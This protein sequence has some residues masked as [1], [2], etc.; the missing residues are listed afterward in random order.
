MIFSRFLF[1]YDIGTFNFLLLKLIIFLNDISIFLLT[2]RF[3]GFHGFGSFLDTFLVT[4]H[5]EYM[6]LQ[7]LVLLNSK[8]IIFTFNVII[9]IIII[10]VFFIFHQILNFVQIF[11]NE[12]LIFLLN[13]IETVPDFNQF[14]VLLLIRLHAMVFLVFRNNLVQKVLS[15]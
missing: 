8:V 7:L 5:L 12:F 1:S 3:L 4:D 14:P 15:I 11:P 10:L 13:F 6:F 9:T 2:I